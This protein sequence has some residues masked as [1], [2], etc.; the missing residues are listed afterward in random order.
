MI[1]LEFLTKDT[2]ISQKVSAKR[3][4]NR[5]TPQIQAALGSKNAPTMSI[6]TDRCTI[7]IKN[8]YTGNGED[9]RVAVRNV[10]RVVV[11]MIN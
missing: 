7:Q 1:G 9:W 5:L 4:Q 10:R 6:L 8:F 11:G 3:Q 2:A